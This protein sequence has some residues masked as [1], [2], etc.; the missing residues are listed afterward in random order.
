MVH[1][2]TFPSFC[3]AASQFSDR[4]VTP[5]GPLYICTNLDLVTNRFKQILLTS[6]VGTSCGWCKKI[7]ELHRII[8]DHPIRAFA[9]VTA[10]LLP[11]RHDEAKALA[12]NHKI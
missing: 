5:L 4:S 1:L 7:L 2:H 8:L 10:L 6:Q 12:M 9:H 3:F 11:R